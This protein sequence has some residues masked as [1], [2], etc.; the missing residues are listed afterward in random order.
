MGLRAIEI[1]NEHFMEKALLG[2]GMT[3]CFDVLLKFGW[4]GLGHRG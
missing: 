4:Q 3:R 1:W 2:E